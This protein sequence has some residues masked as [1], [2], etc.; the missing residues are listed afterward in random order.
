V[1]FRGRFIPAAAPQQPDLTLIRPA[2]AFAVRAAQQCR[3]GDNRRCRAT[4]GRTVRKGLHRL[5]LGAIMIVATAAAS[6][7]DCRAVLIRIVALHRRQFLQLAAVAA[8]APAVSRIAR[9]QPYP[10]RQITLIVP[11]PAGGRD[12]P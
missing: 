1:S 3:A 6:H 8:A 4:T 12:A 11:W 9:A 5:G 10:T 2:D 7:P